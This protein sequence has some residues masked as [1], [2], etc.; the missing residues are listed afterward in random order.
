MEKICI[1]YNIK[2]V[3]ITSHETARGP[4]SAAFGK[5]PDFFFVCLRPQW[6]ARRRRWRRG[7]IVSYDFTV[8][9][10][11]T[12]NNFAKL[13]VLTRTRKTAHN[14]VTLG[15]RFFY[16]FFFCFIFYM[17]RRV[18]RIAGRWSPGRTRRA[19]QV[20]LYIELYDLNVPFRV[21]N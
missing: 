15:Q 12:V 14:G 4:G 7:R 21:E 17:K 20:H 2:I 9:R 3:R 10:W 13:I 18:S 16:N 11:R 19:G 5:D 6:T 8:K 1:L